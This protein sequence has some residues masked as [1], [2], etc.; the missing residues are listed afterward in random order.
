MK[1][2][3]TGDPDLLYAGHANSILKPILGSSS[4]LLLDGERH[5]DE[6]KLMM[7]PFHGERMHAYG[8]VMRS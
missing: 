7:P 5:R 8:Q 1:E 4:L 6:R 2:V 3:F